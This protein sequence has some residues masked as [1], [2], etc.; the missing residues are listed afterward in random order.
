MTT[1]RNG[2]TT[3]ADQCILEQLTGIK[4]LIQLN[5]TD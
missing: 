1:Y 4:Q 3:E 5:L 2:R